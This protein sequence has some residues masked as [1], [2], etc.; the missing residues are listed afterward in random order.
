MKQ[1]LEAG[2]YRDVEE[3]TADL[4]LTFDNAIKYN[5]P[6]SEVTEV[7]KTMEK[8]FDLLWRRR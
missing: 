6:E 4:Q 3:F 5:G 1:K 8:Q 7:A 2:A